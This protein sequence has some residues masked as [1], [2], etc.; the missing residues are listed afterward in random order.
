LTKFARKPSVV[1]D[2]SDEQ[3]Y[4]TARGTGLGN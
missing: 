3:G 4:G 1:I 2:V